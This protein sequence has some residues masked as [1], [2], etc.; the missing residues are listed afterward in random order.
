MPGR[1]RDGKD[2]I[3]VNYGFVTAA[4]V[5]LPAIKLIGVSLSMLALSNCSTV[6]KVDQLGSKYPASP[7]GCAMAMFQKTAPPTGPYET[8]GKIESHLKRNIFFGAKT[9]LEADALTELHFKACD[10]GGNAVLID[11]SVESSAAEM[12]YVHL[13]AT[14]LK[15]P[16]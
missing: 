5:K 16:R 3:N 8:L 6:T 11:D 10:L 13:W 1:G 2:G 4:P 7:E 14:V 15:I 12:N 9:Q